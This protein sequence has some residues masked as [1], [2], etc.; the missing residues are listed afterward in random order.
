MLPKLVEFDLLKFDKFV[1]LF[2]F[3]K[4]LVGRRPETLAEV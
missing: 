1:K 2:D 4:F 3:N